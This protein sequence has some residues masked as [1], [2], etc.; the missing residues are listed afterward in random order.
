M[1]NCITNCDD[2]ELTATFMASQ[3]KSLRVNLS[4]G[5]S[6]MDWIRLTSAHADLSGTGG[7]MPEVTPEELA[8]HSSRTDCWICLDRQVYNVTPYLDFHPGGV[9][10]LLKGAGKDATDLFNSIHSWVNYTGMLKKCYVGK[11]KPGT[12]AVKASAATSTSAKKTVPPPAKAASPTP[13]SPTPPPKTS[14]K[15]DPSKVKNIVMK[16][17]PKKP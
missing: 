4:P 16:Q 15:T 5:H 8:K 11:L 12:N 13:K 6:L 14:P 1:A 7:K 10:Q 9:D 17:V 3:K 2:Y